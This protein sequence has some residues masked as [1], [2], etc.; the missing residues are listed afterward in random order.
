MTTQKQISEGIRTGAGR[1]PG[2]LEHLESRCWDK[3]D[4]R[5]NLIDEQ[6]VVDLRV[7]AEKGIAAYIL[8]HIRK[9]GEVRGALLSQAGY[10]SGTGHAVKVGCFRNKHFRE[11]EEIL[12]INPHNY[13]VSSFGRFYNKIV[14]LDLREAIVSVTVE[15][16][17]FDAG[18]HIYEFKF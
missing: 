2:L 5:S 7:D 8:D 15:N 1:I 11:T 16:T 10:T 9:E 12:A 4:C 13:E 6:I 17:R 18:G 3:S 14:N